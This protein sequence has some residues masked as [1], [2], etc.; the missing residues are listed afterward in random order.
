MIRN[1]PIK[2][3]IYELIPKAETYFKNRKDV[4][5]AYLFGSF[6]TGKPSP[7]SDVDIA[8]YLTGDKISNK[9]LQILGDLT[10]IFKTDEID[11]VILNTAPLSLRM[12]ILKERKILADNTPFFRHSYE[13]M[14][15]RTYLD[16]SKLEKRIL[17]R[18]FLSG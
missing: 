14:T 4:I 15:M 17:E 16:F 1:K 6:A 18:R 10:N 13:S 8:V 5:F 11:L 12:K 2:H 7:L 9:R 3:N